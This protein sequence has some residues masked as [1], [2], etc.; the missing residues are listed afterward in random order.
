MI[1][2]PNQDKN[3]Q[4][5]WCRG[6]ITAIESAHKLILEA[7]A[8]L[9]LDVPVLASAICELEAMKKSCN[10]QLESVIQSGEEYRTK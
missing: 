1:E 6:Y 10:T 7:Q 9:S 5:G 3:Y 8:K 2:R 4:M